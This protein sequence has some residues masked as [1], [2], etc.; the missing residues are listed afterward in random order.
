MGI[1]GNLLKPMGLKP[2]ENTTQIW[3][4]NKKQEIKKIYDEL[5][6][7]APYYRAHKS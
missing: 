7:R 6:A 5:D 3:L 4:N 2:E 1:E